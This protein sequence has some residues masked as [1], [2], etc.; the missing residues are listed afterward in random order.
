MAQEDEEF[1]YNHLDESYIDVAKDEKGRKLEYQKMKDYVRINSP[2]HPSGR[3]YTC[4]EACCSI[5]TGYHCCHTTSDRSDLEKYGVGVVLYFKF[6]KMLIFY[7]MIF[8]I[9]AIPSLYY[10]ITAFN[11]YNLES[12][13]TINH[14]LLATTLGA[15]GLGNIDPDLALIAWLGTS[16]CNL[17]KAP[18]GATTSDQQLLAFTCPSGTLGTVANIVYGFCNLK[19]YYVI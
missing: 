15:L 6:V 17:G 13:L 5:N 7:F 3:D 10:T 8:S 16:S 4:C 9:L 12:D 19:Q 2:Q 1:Y 14:Y 11:N 18:L